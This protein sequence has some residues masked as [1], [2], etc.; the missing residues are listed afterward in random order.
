MKVPEDTQKRRSIFVFGEKNL[1]K[2][3]P[4]PSGKHRKRIVKKDEMKLKKPRGQNRYMMRDKYLNAEKLKS[5][6][7]KETI[8]KYVINTNREVKLRYWP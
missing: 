4:V 1:T 2:K 7:R 6:Q 5:A 8:R 3:I